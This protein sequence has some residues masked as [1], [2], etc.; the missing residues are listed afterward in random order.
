MLKDANRLLDRTLQKL[1]NN[2]ASLVCQ[3]TFQI[4]RSA[5]MAKLRIKRIIILKHKYKIKTFSKGKQ[6]SYIY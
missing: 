4:S 2:T 3:V 6:Y 5:L 1:Q